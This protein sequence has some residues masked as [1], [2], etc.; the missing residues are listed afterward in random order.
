MRYGGKG[1]DNL[2][3]LDYQKQLNYDLI[4]NQF[5]EIPD[6]DD[7]E[8]QREL[9]YD[10]IGEMIGVDDDIKDLIIDKD[11]VAIGMSK[12]NIIRFP[13]STDEKNMKDKK[14]D[15]NTYGLM[16]LFSKY[17]K[18]EDHRYITEDDLILNQSKIEEYSKN[19]FDTVKRNIKKL[20]KLESS[21]VVAKIINGKTT[22]II[23]YKNKDGRKY[24]T[25]EEEILKTLLNDLKSSTIK[26]YMLLKYRCK[27]KTFTRIIKESINNNIGLNSDSGKNKKEL[28]KTLD[29][30]RDI[31]LIEKYTKT[32]KIQNKN[33]KIVYTPVTYIRLVSYEEYIERRR[34]KEEREKRD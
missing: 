27:T 20:A 17:T 19:K 8:S 31:D 3:E 1:G 26:V 10:L 13:I 22:Y 21:L 11:T 30:L 33:G 16:T 6:I 34:E 5:N 23:N 9:D 32:E 12:D 15:Y 4:G 28:N 25:I 2:E 29:L 14:C 24:V 18:G 7:T